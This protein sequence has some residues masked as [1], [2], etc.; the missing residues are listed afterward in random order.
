MAVSQTENTCPLFL[1]LSVAKFCWPHN[2]EGVVQ[3]NDQL[4]RIIC[5][6]GCNSSF[7]FSFLSHHWPILSEG[8]MI[9][10]LF[11]K[12]TIEINCASQSKSPETVRSSHS[13][14]S[15][16]S[17]NFENRILHHLHP[18]FPCHSLRNQ[19]WRRWKVHLE[20]KFRHFENQNF[21]IFV[22]E[23]IG[24]SAQKYFDILT[25]TSN[26]TRKRRTWSL[27]Q[28]YARYLPEQQQALWRRSAQ[29]HLRATRWFSDNEIYSGF[30]ISWDTSAEDATSS[31]QF[32]SASRQGTRN[33]LTLKRFND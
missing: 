12:I 13:F 17:S 33:N 15:R 2:I 9:K 18:H 11:E 4:L 22:T 29:S 10:T 1:L 24:N 6:A 31:A 16:K 26:K 5:R 21:A 23:W 19:N 7:F 20:S 30:P 28:V 3:Q 32:W 14:R 25:R 8:K 27:L